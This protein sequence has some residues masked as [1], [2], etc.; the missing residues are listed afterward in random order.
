MPS[1]LKINDAVVA[2]GTYPKIEVHPSY[3]TQQTQ[4]LTG[5]MKHAF[6]LHDGSSV[7]IYFGPRQNGMTSDGYQWAGD[8]IK[9][10]AGTDAY[11]ELMDP[12]HAFYKYIQNHLDS[13]GDYT[14]WMPTLS[15]NVSA[16]LDFSGLTNVKDASELYGKLSELVGTE[17]RGLIP[18]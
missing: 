14:G 9:M 17:L 16:K 1:W 10:K 3:L 2:P 6:E 13:N 12:G 7:K 18:A 8:F 4:D 15:D 11:K 5:I